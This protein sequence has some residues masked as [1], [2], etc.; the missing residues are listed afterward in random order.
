M[1]SVSDT[2]RMPT[3][4]LD[5]L[6]APVVEE[7]LKRSD[8]AIL[9]LGPTEA[10]GLHLP[11]GCDYLIALATAELAAREADALVLPPFA[12][13]WPGAT[14]KL[15][16]TMRLPPDLVQQVLLAILEGAVAQGF[17]RLALVCAHGPDVFTATAAARHAFERLGTPVAVHHAVPG[18]GTTPREHGLAEPALARDREEP[19]YGETSRMMA[20]LEFLALPS[21]LVDRAA[22]ERGPV[23]VAP[24]PAALIDPVRSGGAG[25]FYTDLPQHIPTPGGYSIEDG[26]AY[27]EA[28]AAAIAESLAAMLALG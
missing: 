6:T 22:I 25:F 21:E 11:L 7:Y 23:R 1:R 20:A 18:R 15:P 24:P 19:G 4:R 2:H 9:P 10:H 17:R 3:R 14:A 26:R 13:S 8:A 5:Y 16:G 27:L 12:Y 28:V